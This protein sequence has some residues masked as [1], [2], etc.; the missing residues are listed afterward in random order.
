MILR[1]R[2]RNGISTP[3]NVAVSTLH[4]Q[5]E[6]KLV[7][8]QY[9]LHMF[10][11]YGELRPI[12]GWDWFTSLGNPSKFQQVSRLGFITAPT[13][14]NRR[15]PSTKLHDV[16]PSLGLVQ[17]AEFPLC[18][19]LAFYI[20]RLTARHSTSGHQPNFAR[21]AEGA[22]YIWQGGHHVII[23]QVL[24]LLCLWMLLYLI[25]L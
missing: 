7:K 12:S 24:P 20:G 21:W 22:A 23:V 17:G 14:L 8:Q 16:W 2:G 5:S 9:L 4:R 13:L 19:S 10:S 15:Q 3:Q 6:K 1:V 18:P 25:P 11:Q